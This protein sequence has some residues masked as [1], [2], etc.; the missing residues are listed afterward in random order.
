[1]KIYKAIEINAKK[2]KKC[3]WS[4]STYST[5]WIWIQKTREEKRSLDE[6]SDDMT[7]KHR[8]KQKKT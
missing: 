7:E 3:D 1:M 6:N 2:Q 5:E 8:E 4:Y